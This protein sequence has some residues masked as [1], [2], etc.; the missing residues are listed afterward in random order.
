[1]CLGIPA[2]VVEKVDGYAGQVALVEIEGA[3]RKVNV[4]MLEDQDLEPGDWVVVHMGFALERL[5][6]AG[7][8][9]VLAGLDMMG[10]PPS[11]P[12]T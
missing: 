8:K 5:D 1:M 3:H 9:Q 10:G 11:A 4:G 7:A 2:Q 12:Q 6:E